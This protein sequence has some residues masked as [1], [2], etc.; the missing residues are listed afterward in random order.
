MNDCEATE[1]ASRTFA[2][3]KAYGVTPRTGLSR[4]TTATSCESSFTV[5]HCGSVCAVPVCNGDEPAVYGGS[6]VEYV[7]RTGR[8][9]PGVHA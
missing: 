2:F 7:E 3:G 9:A 1:G 5:A 6:Y 4:T 8:E